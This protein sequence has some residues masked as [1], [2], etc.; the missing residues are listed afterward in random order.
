MED[1]ILDS[2]ELPPGGIAKLSLTLPK[3]RVVVFEPITHSATFLVVEGAETRER[4]G[5]SVVYSDEGLLMGS[6]KLNPGSLLL[7][8]E[9]RSNVRVLP[10]VWITG[11]GVHTS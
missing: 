1:A 10:A 11:A 9:N 2:V 5:I 6:A 7:S 4:Q 3:S 8:L